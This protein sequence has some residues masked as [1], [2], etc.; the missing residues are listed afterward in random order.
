MANQALISYIRVLS[1][2]CANL[3]H[4]LNEIFLQPQCIPQT[5]RA[6]S[7]TMALHVLYTGRYVYVLILWTNLD[8]IW[9]STIQNYPKITSKISSPN[10]HT[11]HTVG[12][13]KCYFH[14]IK[15]NKTK[16]K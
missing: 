7:I 4:M 10:L 15:F 1:Y 2:G 3:Y 13:F 8:Y 6:N 11:T 5:E 9:H 16:F 14:M 12:E